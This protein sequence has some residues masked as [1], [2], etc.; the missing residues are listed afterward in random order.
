MSTHPQSVYP[1]WY[2]VPGDRQRKQ[3]ALQSGVDAVVK[4]VLIGVI[5]RKGNAV[6]KKHIEVLV[7]IQRRW[8]IIVTN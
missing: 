2:T 1:S 3:R 7:Q 4:N 6:S 5:V 8:V